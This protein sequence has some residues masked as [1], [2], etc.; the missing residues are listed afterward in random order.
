MYLS[1]SVSSA[2]STSSK[3]PMYNTSLM[4]FAHHASPMYTKSYASP[5]RFG[6]SSSP[7]SPVHA[8]P[9]SPV[10]ASPSSPVRFGS[11]PSPSSPVRFGSFPSPSSPL[12]FGSFPSPSSPV[13]VES[14][15]S[16]L[17]FGS[18]PSPSSPVRF[19]SFPSPTSPEHTESSTSPE[20][21]E[22]STS[23]EHTESSTS[24]LSHA[25]SIRKNPR[26]HRRLT[27][28]EQGTV[29]SQKGIVAEELFTRKSAC[30]CC[31]SFLSLYR[32]KK[33]CSWIDAKCSRCKSMFEVKCASATEENGT[34]EI[35]GGSWEGW[36]DI[37]EVT[38]MTLKW[39]GIVVI[40][41]S[42][43]EYLISNVFFIPR[44]RIGRNVK[45]VKKVDETR[46]R[47]KTRS[48]IS[49]YN[50]KGIHRV[51]FR[52]DR[53][54]KTLIYDLVDSI[55]DKNSDNND[56]EDTIKAHFDTT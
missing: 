40:I 29:D 34:L 21:T 35:K 13:H 7:S 26:W 43:C 54:P 51:D 18:F 55:L 25:R 17:C 30:P 8:S 16:P 38:N 6:S 47:T 22:S 3:Y 53:L 23:P 11:F 1:R 37:D 27:I 19:G 20:H 10:H 56:R 31:G 5:V 14:S 52:Y 44:A 39:K 45:I 4:R 28:Q 9:S 36:L 49:I 42:G 41:T 2:S 50:M 24:P 33:E 32:V 12:R 46:Y 15:G 48:T